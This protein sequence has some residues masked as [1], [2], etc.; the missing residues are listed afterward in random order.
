LPLDS[1][2]EVSSGNDRSLPYKILV[3]KH[4]E[5]KKLANMPISAQ[6]RD[7]LRQNGYLRL[8]GAIPRSMVDAAVHAINHRL[9]QGFPAEELVKFQAQSF[10]PDLQ[11]QPVISDL[12]NA[13]GVRESLEELLG[14]GN[15]EARKSGQL[16][17]RFPREPGTQPTPPIAHIDGVH[18]PNNGVPKGTLAS[19]TA[20][21]GVFLTDV[22]S[23]YAGN[24]AV[25]P[26]SHLKMEKYFQENGIDELLHE[27]RTPK[28]PYGEGKQVHAR[29]GDVVIA[30]YQLLHGI[31]MNLA[32]WPRYAVFFRVTHPLHARNR[33]ECL[34][35]LWLEWPGVK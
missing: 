31:T 17:L 4:S 11:T 1:V 13:S 19:F 34:T 22:S 29:A 10:F 24:F 33:L 18:H 23:D 15:V 28:L 8:D 6:H 12:F 9:G 7:D 30:H 2:A 20:L 25:W 21:V 32:P 26:G 5:S 35:N 27:G 3:E 16:A 14:Q